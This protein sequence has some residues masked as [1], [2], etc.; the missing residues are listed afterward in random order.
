LGSWYQGGSTGPASDRFAL[1]TIDKNHPWARGALSDTLESLPS[2]ES[3]NRTSESNEPETTVP[4]LIFKDK[5]GR[6]CGEYVVPSTP[7]AS[8]VGIACRSVAGRWSIETHTAHPTGDDAGLGAS[9]LSAAK[10]PAGP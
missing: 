10:K 1:L 8:A 9:S 3:R 2:G 4:V 7:E 6:F 5:A